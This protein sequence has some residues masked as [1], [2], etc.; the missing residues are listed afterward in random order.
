[1]TAICLGFKKTIKT[2]NGFLQQQSFSNRLRI[3][4]WHVKLSLNHVWMMWGERGTRK[5]TKE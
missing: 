4:M 1:M 5:K 2:G 3:S